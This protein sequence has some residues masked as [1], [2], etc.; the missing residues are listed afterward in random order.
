MLMVSK[1]FI[2]CLCKGVCIIRLF[3]GMEHEKVDKKNSLIGLW[4]IY[5]GYIA[6]VILVIGLIVYA[7]RV[8][9]YGELAGIIIATIILM[10]VTGVFELTLGIASLIMIGHPAKYGFFIATGI[11]LCALSLVGLI[12]S[13]AG[14]NINVTSLGVPVVL[15]TLIGLVISVLYI[16]GGAR[17]KN[18]IQLTT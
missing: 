8:S 4:L 7:T 11:I 6:S 18:A 10:L 5:G 17:L 2:N 16:I 12:L 15:L 1:L 9:L 14:R 3:W 13:I